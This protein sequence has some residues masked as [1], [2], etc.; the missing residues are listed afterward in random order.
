MGCKT[1]P[2]YTSK[3]RDGRIC[4]VEA[5]E[6]PVEALELKNAVAAESGAARLCRLTR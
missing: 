4:P 2:G 6:F 3:S 1:L 5:L